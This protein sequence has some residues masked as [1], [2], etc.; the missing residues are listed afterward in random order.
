MQNCFTG[1]KKK[2]TDL[3]ENLELNCFTGVKKSH[4]F[5]EDSIAEL[6]HRC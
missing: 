6:F 1:V 3:K 2:V 4:S 5:E